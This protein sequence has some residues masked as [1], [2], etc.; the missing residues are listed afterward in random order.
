MRPDGKDIKIKAF[1]KQVPHDFLVK[2]ITLL[3][4]G[5]KV[6]F[7]RTDEEM[8]IKKK[9]SFKSDKPLCFKIEIE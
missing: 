5:E 3:S 4:T 6:E 7:E 1:K 2:E 9:P 8:I